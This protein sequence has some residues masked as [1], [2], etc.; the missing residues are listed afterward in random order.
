MCIKCDGYKDLWLGSLVI[1]WIY[2][3]FCQGD[4][5]TNCPTLKGILDRC[6]TVTNV[7]VLFISNLF[8]VVILV[9]FASSV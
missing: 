7:T 6:I 9:S 1:F 8:L 4:I 2:L 3:I 5:I